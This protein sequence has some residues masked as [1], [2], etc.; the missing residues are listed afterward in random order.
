VVTWNVHGCVAGLE[1]IID[2]LRRL[3]ADVICLQ[4]A[5]AGTSHTDGADQAA[6]IARELGLRQFSA[7]STLP[8]GGEQRMAI[9]CKQSLREPSV[10]EAGTGRVYG[11]T[12]IMPWQGRSLRIVCVHLTSSYRLD[13]KHVL[14]TSR[15]RLKE[16]TDLAKRL[17]SWPGQCIVAGDFNSTPGMPAH[18]RVAKHLGGTPTT[19]P[20]YPSESPVLAIDHVLCSSGLQVTHLTVET[21]HASDHLLVLAEISRAAGSPPF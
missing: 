19:Q 18:D 10:L 13:P 5:E 16:A 3:E 4:E 20:T 1:P 15:A 12:A 8:D 11:V 2:E 9:V 17:Q 7:G 21:T 14:K 6:S